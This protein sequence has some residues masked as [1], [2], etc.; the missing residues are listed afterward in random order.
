MP[1]PFL[2][3]VYSMKFRIL[4]IF[5]GTLTCYPAPSSRSIFHYSKINF[6]IV[7]MKKPTMSVLK[8][9]SSV[10][11]LAEIFQFH[12]FL[13]MSKCLL[14]AAFP[15]SPQNE[16]FTL[17]EHPFTITHLSSIINYIFFLNHNAFFLQL[18][19]V[20][21]MVPTLHGISFKKYLNKVSGGNKQLSGACPYQQ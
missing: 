14:Q 20:Q 9:F 6:I 15:P 7:I 12:S 8:A 19:F 5:G 18:H 21:P 13:G 3:C 17:E 10:K 11:E 2:S 16:F 4:F 1:L